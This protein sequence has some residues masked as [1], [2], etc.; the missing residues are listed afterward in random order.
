MLPRAVVPTL[1]LAFATST[2]AQGTPSV[3]P[4]VSKLPPAEVQ[5]AGP[6]Q[7]AAQR[8]V[9]T[10][11]KVKAVDVDKRTLVIEDAKGATQTVQVGPSVKRLQDVAPGDTINVTYEQTLLLEN[12]PAGSGVADR[13]TGTLRSDAREAP[14]GKQ[15]TLTRGDVQVTKIDEKSRTVTLK[16]GN[17]KTFTVKAGPDIDLAKVKVGQTFYATYTEVTA[18]KVEKAAAKAAPA[19]K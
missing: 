1:V 16:D 5:R 8:S 10:T 11:V 14:G 6:G 7:G 17:G 13:T 12:L 4:D 3:R 15:G 19:A 9:T 2:L 18:V